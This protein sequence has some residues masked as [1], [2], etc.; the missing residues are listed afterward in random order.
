MKNQVVC[1]PKL[2]KKLMIIY[3][4]T[5][6]LQKLRKKKFLEYKPPEQY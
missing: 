1:Y 2:A 6:R 5:F 4:V 3:G